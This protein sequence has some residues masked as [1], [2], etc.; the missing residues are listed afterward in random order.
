MHNFNR[1]IH[2]FN[3]KMHNFNEKCII[4]MEQCI[5]FM[6]NASFVYLYICKFVN[7]A[8]SE[9]Y[10]NS[11][12]KVGLKTVK[13]PLNPYGEAKKKSFNLTTKF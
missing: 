6:K 3:R 1:K 13:K 11:I 8:S 12:K 9:I 5:I 2:Y 4:L 10:G 7:S